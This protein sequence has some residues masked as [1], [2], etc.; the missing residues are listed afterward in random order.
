M[1]VVVRRKVGLLVEN[2]A[3]MRVSVFEEVEAC[4][5]TWMYT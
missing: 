1:N 4:K 5:Y 3:G 2:E